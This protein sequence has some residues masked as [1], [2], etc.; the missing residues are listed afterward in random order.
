METKFRDQLFRYVDFSAQSKTLARKAEAELNSIVYTMI[1]I[2]DSM[3]SVW[4]D[5]KDA[6]TAR[7]TH[8]GKILS[9]ENAKLLSKIHQLFHPYGDDP[10][11]SILVEEICNVE[12]KLVPTGRCITLFM[13]SDECVEILLP[14]RLWELSH[15]PAVDQSEWD[16]QFLKYIMTKVD[17]IIPPVGPEDPE[18]VLLRKLAAKHNLQLTPVVQDENI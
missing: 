16:A 4:E 7:L 18:I 12:I 11:P 9:P 8:G 15:Q 17:V 10:E 6:I 13:T 3:D 2:I 1:Y 14:D 5:N